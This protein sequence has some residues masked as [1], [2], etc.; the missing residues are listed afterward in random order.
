VTKFSSLDRM[1]VPIGMSMQEKQ[2]K[3][4]RLREGLRKCMADGV[5]Q[6]WRSIQKIHPE[7]PS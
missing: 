6:V 3:R 5:P 1:S 2:E 7:N 4:A